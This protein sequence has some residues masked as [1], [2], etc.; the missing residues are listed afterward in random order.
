MDEKAEAPDT[1]KAV[2]NINFYSREGV[3]AVLADIEK[4]RMLFDPEKTEKDMQN[5]EVQTMLLDFVRRVSSDGGNKTPEEVRI[6]PEMVR[7]YI[8]GN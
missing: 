8:N 3:K 2:L 6:L 5:E 4:R 7:L 1:Y